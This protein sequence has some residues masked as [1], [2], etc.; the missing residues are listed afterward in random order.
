[1][2]LVLGAEV[3]DQPDQAVLLLGHRE[4]SMGR[5]R[6]PPREF[7]TEEALQKLFPPEIRREA[8]K[9]AKPKGKKNTRREDSGD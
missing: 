2:A 5:P 9:V 4:P 7:T 8:R 3:L 6:K 1:V